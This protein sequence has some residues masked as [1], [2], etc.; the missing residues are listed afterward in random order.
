MKRLEFAR[1]QILRTG[2]SQKDEEEQLV[3]LAMQGMNAKEEKFSVEFPNMQEAF[4]WSNKYRPR[5]PHFFN[6]VH[7]VGG[8]FLFNL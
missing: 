2:Q 8:A 6:R 3:R 5:K 1:M 4:I 7:T